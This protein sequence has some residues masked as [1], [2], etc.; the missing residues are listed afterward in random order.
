MRMT[1]ADVM[2]TKVVSVTATTPFKDI[3]QALITGGISAV[4]VLD[5]DNHVLGM[6]SEADLL[7]RTVPGI[8]R[9]RHHIRSS[10]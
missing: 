2:T 6:V 4:P 9:V 7:A 3:A 8:V 10:P 5:D 1:V